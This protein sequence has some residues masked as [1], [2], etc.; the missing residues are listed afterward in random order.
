[1]QIKCS[2]KAQK[3]LSTNRSPLE[4]N[5]K[6]EYIPDLK[7]LLI[8][9]LGG[10]PFWLILILFILVTIRSMLNLSDKSRKIHKESTENTLQNWT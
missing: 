5:V 1:M 9:I 4:L 6:H 3:Q 10:C 2:T 8:I 7:K